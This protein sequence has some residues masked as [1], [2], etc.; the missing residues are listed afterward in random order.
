MGKVLGFS[1]QNAGVL[2]GKQ[3]IGRGGGWPKGF[4]FHN[5]SVQLPM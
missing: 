4:F 3:S 2:V 1:Y 5:A